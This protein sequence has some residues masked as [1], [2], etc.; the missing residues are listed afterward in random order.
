[1]ATGQQNPREQIEDVLALVRRTLRY[2]WVVGLITVLGTAAAVAFALSRP[3]VY[4]ASTVIM[5][6]DVIPSDLLHGSRG[7]SSERYMRARF[8]EMLYARPLLEKVITE[9]GAFEKLIAK[10]NMAFAVDRLRSHIDFRGRGGG[11]FRIAYLGRTP[12][13]AQQITKL[14]AKHLIEWELR[15]QLES[16]SITKNFLEQEAKR[17]TTDLHKAEREFAKFLAEHP[18]FADEVLVATG[19]A[20]AS[21]RKRNPMVAGGGTTVAKAPKGKQR[22]YALERQRE[23]LYA[24]LNRP[25]NAKPTRRPS[26]PTEEERVAERAVLRARRDLAREKSRLEN[27][28]LKYTDLHPDVQAAQRRISNAT[29]ILT[30]AEA[31][32]ER[33]KANRPKGVIVKNVSA[34]EKKRLRAEINRLDRA[35]V[36]ERKR[37]ASKKDSSGDKVEDAEVDKDTAEVVG[38]ETRWS[39]LFRRVK[40]MRERTASIE[41]KAFTADIMANSEIARQGVQLTVVNPAQLPTHPAGMGRKLVVM[42]GFF[43]SGLLGLG[44]AITLVLMDDRIFGRRDIE[45]LEIAPVLT[46]VPSH[47]SH[48][49]RKR[50]G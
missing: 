50:R 4:Q 40:D 1:M 23:R 22:L 6:R 30:A 26:Q 20:G 33:A 29:G 44:L 46:I 43:V 42:A 45:R 48:K 36:A 3:R 10:K 9:S 21:I 15:M 8:G 12:K 17:L 37:L 47:K 16:V 11:T 28:R 41:S 24:R 14:L 32:L 39:K 38:L 49:R 7:S 35:I 13:L 18:E 5:H 2:W 25:A 31:R 34:A 19:A 27:L